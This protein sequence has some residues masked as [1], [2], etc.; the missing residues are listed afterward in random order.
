MKLKTLLLVGFAAVC[1]SAFAE[2][3]PGTSA[4]DSLFIRDFTAKPGDTVEVILNLKNETG[5]AALQSDFHYPE[6]I[7]AAQVDDY[8]PELD[9][10]TMVWAKPINRAKKHQIGAAVSPGTSLR[11]VM[12]NLQNLR[13]PPRTEGDLGIVKLYIAIDKNLAAGVYDCYQDNIC[14]STANPDESG[15]GYF[16]GNMKAQI[17]FKITVDPSAV[18]DVNASKEISSVKYYN[19]AGVESAEPFQGINIVVTTYADGSKTTN[20]VVK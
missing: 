5:Y 8:D 7:T 6:G 2:K 13:I 1:M 11:I 19:V 18:N 14:Y 4:T 20:K 12:F 15:D 3:D 9:T 16:G 17:P 10:H